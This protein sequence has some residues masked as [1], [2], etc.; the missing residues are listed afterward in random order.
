MEKY[1]YTN[2]RNVQIVLSLLK[3]HRIRKVVVSPGATN[4]TLVASMQQDSFFEMYSC[5]DE[6]S[7][8]YMACGM[9]AEFDEPIVLSCT[10]ATSSRNYMPGLTE[11]YYRKLPILAITS[12]MSIA[13]V[14]HL[15]AQVTDRSNPPKDII[16]YTTC[17]Q[18]VKDAEDEW[19]CM[20]K[21]NKAILELKRRG[22]GP[23]HINLTTVGSRDYSVKELPETQ[24]IKRF[25]KKEDFPELPKGRIGVFVGVHS[26]W[27]QEQTDIL[28]KFCASNNAIVLCDHSSNF[29]GKYRAQYSLIAGQEHYVSELC[30]LD[31]LIHI[32]EISGDY[33]TF[34]RLNIKEVWRVSED[35]EIRDFFHKLHYVFE[36]KEEDF[37]AFYSKGDRLLS[38]S[39]LNEF[40]LEYNRILAKIPTLPFSNIYVASI[41]SS[42][43]PQKSVLHLGILNSLRAWN[44]FEIPQSVLSYS[45]VGGF[46][47]DGIMSTLIGA[48][49]A[50]KNKLYFA[51]IGDLAF[52]Y[53]LNSLGNHHVG[54][55]IRIL[56]INNGRGIEFRNYSHAASVFGDITDKYIA[57]AGH[58]GNKSAQLVKHY[59]EDLG[60]EYMCA[61]NKEEFNSVYEHFISPVMGQRSIIF[62]VFTTSDDESNALKLMNHIEEDS[63]L[64]TAA[65]LKKTFRKFVGNNTVK[66]IKN[67]IKK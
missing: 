56:L 57:A 36:T 5:V 27:S 33:Y 2:E 15:Y 25:C 65:V 67:V 39:F 24:E 18:T 54:N 40:K 11:A 3:A 34:N 8:A 14:G 38:D 9:A 58:F 4:V 51:V 48:S 66:M 22:G 30:N 42:R 64:K 50:D 20:I 44:F 10:G 35:G 49:L 28:D 1:Y 45:N 16:K 59:A 6:R 12:T 41:L 53:D 17:L 32:G 52:F 55:N 62:E 26:K 29:K 46:G 13:K 31:L 47:I 43:L 60:Y 23:V 21:A 61:R 19:D 37:F 7:A 63:S